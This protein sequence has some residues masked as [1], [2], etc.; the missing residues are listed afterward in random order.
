MGTKPKFIFNKNSQKRGNHGINYNSVRIQMVRK[1]KK[2]YPSDVKTFDKISD[3]S[4][5][6]KT[7]RNEDFMIFNN[8]DIVIFQSP[9]QAKIYSKYNEDIFTDG[10]FSIAPKCGR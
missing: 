1:M 7:L 10:K 8:S 5:Y 9:F 2:Q 3:E 6:F 4:D